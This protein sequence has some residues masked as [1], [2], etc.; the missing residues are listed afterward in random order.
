MTRRARAAGCFT[1]SRAR[2]R[3]SRASRSAEPPGS[4]DRATR[5][6]TSGPTRHSPSS[7][8][9][10]TSTSRSSPSPSPPPSCSSA[11]H[12]L[13]SHSPADDRRTGMCLSGRPEDT[14]SHGCIRQALSC[15]D[16]VSDAS[17]DGRSVAAAAEVFRRHNVVQAAYMLGSAA[18]NRLRP[19][20]DI[21]AR[22][23]GVDRRPLGRGPVRHGRF[24]KRGRSPIRRHRHERAP[25]DRRFRAPRLD[26]AGRSPGRIDLSLSRWLRPRRPR[27]E[28]FRRGHQ[29]RFA[30]RPSAYARA[31][32]CRYWLKSAWAR[33][34]SR[35]PS[36]RRA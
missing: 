24:S 9:A 6:P 20:S 5:S 21:D 7:R 29:P 15:G 26:S 11:S 17:I 36:R 8:S 22:T 4:T 34:R 1:T 25:L 35:T 23:G 19:D 3:A 18:T 28:P 33:E 30:L 32:A 2:P 12:S 31:A 27:A 14:L 16:T 10:A 13:A